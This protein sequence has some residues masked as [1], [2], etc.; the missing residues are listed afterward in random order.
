MNR[1]KTNSTFDITKS[2]K[3]MMAL[4]K[5]KDLSEWKN[6]MIEAQVAEVKSKTTKFVPKE[7]S[8]E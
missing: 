2:T 3:R 5:F 7:P 6:Q 4:M 1:P 8:P